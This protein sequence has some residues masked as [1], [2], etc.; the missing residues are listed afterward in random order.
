MDEK[1]LCKYF[2]TIMLGCI[3]IEC[4]NAIQQVVPHKGF[5]FSGFLAVKLA[6]LMQSL[7]TWRTAGKDASVQHPGR[8]S[9]RGHI[10]P[11]VSWS[12]TSLFCTNMAIPQ[13]KGRGERKWRKVSDIVTPTLATFCSAATQKRDREAHLNYY[14]STYNMGRQL[15]HRKTKLNQIQQNTR[16]NLN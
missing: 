16:L 10:P 15:S 9:W 14:A 6:T 2:C 3:S 8:P 12:L 11:V 5:Q 1:L 7:F 13:T 4:Y